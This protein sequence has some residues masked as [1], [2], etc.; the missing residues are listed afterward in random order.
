MALSDMLF[1]LMS[2]PGMDA[3]YAKTLINEAWGDVRRMGGWSFQ[4]FETGFTVPG[5]LST[6][7]VTLTFGSASVTGDATASAAWL[8]T[9]QYGSLLSQRQFRSG[10]TSGAGTIY[11]IVYVDVTNPSAVVLTLNRPFAD[12]LTSLT[13][14]VASQ[15]YM[16]YQPYIAAPYQDFDRWLTV[17]DIANS[18]WLFVKGN[19]REV[20]LSDPQRQIFANPDRLLALG[21]DSRT[22]SSTYGWQRYELWPGPQNQYL[23]QAWGV[24]NGSDLV[25]M[26]DTLPIGI[27][28]SMVKARARA[29]CYENAEATKDP[30][31][32]RGAVSDYRF[33]IGVAMKQYEG[34][35]KQARLRDRNRCDI[36]YS[37]MHRFR[38]GPAPATFDP[39][40]GGVRAQ[41]GV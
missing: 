26:T 38:G 6:G 32:P 15:Q 28:E 19:R 24:R 2:I 35:L 40:T 21:E 14:P 39:A 12:P 23:Y 5:A 17:F 31:N 4:L 11:D 29:R 36:F 10:G 9:S 25:N 34:E 1:E 3:A 27:P 20:G 13:A 37:T 41:V 33:L 22:G 7:T 16:I 30:Q 18:G 8:T